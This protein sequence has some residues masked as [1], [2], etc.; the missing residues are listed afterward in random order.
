MSD[1]DQLIAE[2]KTM[3]KSSVAMAVR[4]SAD[5]CVCFLTNDNRGYPEPV[6]SKLA[7]WLSKQKFRVLVRAG[8]K[9]IASLGLGDNWPIAT[10]LKP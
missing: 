9:P 7:G 3:V 6:I 5:V 1:H 2:A 10:S 4:Q 8:I